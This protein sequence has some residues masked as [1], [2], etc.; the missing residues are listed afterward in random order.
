MTLFHRFWQ[1]V[2][3]SYYCTQCHSEIDADNEIRGSIHTARSESWCKE[4]REV[5]DVSTC[6]VPYWTVAATL[7]LSLFVQ[8]GVN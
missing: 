3:R 2:S 6:K 4:C 5:V 8:F 7:G 1:H